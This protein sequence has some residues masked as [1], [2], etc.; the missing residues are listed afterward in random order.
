MGGFR[1][2][3]KQYNLTFEDPA[4]DRLEVKLTGMS[5]DE[6]LDYDLAR[7]AA[8]DGVER[9]AERTRAVAETIAA[10]L[11]SWSLVEEDGSPTPLTAKGLL[12]HDPEVQHAIALAYA[13]AVRGVPVPLGSGSTNGA[14]VDSLPTETLPASP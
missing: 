10:H 12:S 1:L 8:W 4:L 14:G 3:P 13:L 5:M 11:V 6:A 7:L 9:N 2:E